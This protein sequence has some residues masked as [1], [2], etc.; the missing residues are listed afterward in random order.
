M[1]YDYQEMRKRFGEA[2]ESLQLFNNYRTDFEMPK[3]S[4]FYIEKEKL[5][6]EELRGFFGNSKLEYCGLYRNNIEKAV[7]KWIL[8]GKPV[9]TDLTLYRFMNSYLNRAENGKELLRKWF[10]ESKELKKFNSILK[11][12]IKDIK[13]GLYNMDVPSITNDL[14]RLFGLKKYMKENKFPFYYIYLDSQIQPK[15]VYKLGFKGHN[16]ILTKGFEVLSLPVESSRADIRYINKQPVWY[17]G[18]DMYQ[19][20]PKGALYRLSTSKFLRW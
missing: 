10:F 7:R 18:H 3:I 9:E 6:F 11:V 5:L 17:C 2:A 15:W 12:S 1:L 8:T 14:L 19:K 20:L 13:L 16:I 4:S